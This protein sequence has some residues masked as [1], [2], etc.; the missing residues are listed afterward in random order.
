MNYSN[1]QQIKVGD[2]VVVD[3][4]AGHVVCDFDNREFLDGYEG[5][6]MPTVEMLIGGTLS[7]GVM[8]ETEEA[9]LVHYAD[10]D[11]GNIRAVSA[12]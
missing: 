4:M 8:I 1:G 5:W 9:G 6:D 10:E 7:S 12:D 2:L 11:K 3:G